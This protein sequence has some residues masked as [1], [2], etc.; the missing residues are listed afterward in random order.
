MV[1][2]NPSSF[3]I[4]V[5]RLLG[6]SGTGE[7]PFPSLLGKFLLSPRNPLEPEEE[8]VSLTTPSGWSVWETDS[9]AKT[10]RERRTKRNFR[11]KPDVPPYLLSDLLFCVSGLTGQTVGL[12]TQRSAVLAHSSALQASASRAGCRS[13][14]DLM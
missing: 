10:D 3:T 11:F 13:E 1:Y 2:R 9:I 7:D 12:V 8:E 6:C 5:L 4:Q 14:N